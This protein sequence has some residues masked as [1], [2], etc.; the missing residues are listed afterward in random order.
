MT[1]SPSEA[2]A[3]ATAFLT[4]FLAIESATAARLLP[5]VGRIA[6]GTLEPTVLRAALG[7][8]AA[9]PRRYDRRSHRWRCWNSPVC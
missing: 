8:T 2:Q 7:A 5:L 9:H 4:S 6:A 3:L 1:A